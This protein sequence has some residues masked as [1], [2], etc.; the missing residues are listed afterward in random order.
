MLFSSSLPASDIESLHRMVQR[1]QTGIVGSAASARASCDAECVT[2]LPAGLV[3]YWPLDGDGQDRSGAGNH[4]TPANGEW[5]TGIFG[6]AFK[7]DGDDVVEIPPSPSL[8]GDGLRALTALAWVHP[9]ALDPTTD[10]DIIIN[11]GEQKTP[12]SLGLFRGST[13]KGY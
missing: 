2:A 5:A 1:S 8:N 4:G 7:F 9:T 6:L 11:R 10:V 12:V 3:G 13:L